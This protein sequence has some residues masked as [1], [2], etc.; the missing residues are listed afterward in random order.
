MPIDQT[1]FVQK[2]TKLRNLTKIALQ[3]SLQ[4]FVNFSQGVSILNELGE[5]MSEDFLDLKHKND[6]KSRDVCLQIVGQLSQSFQFFRESVF[7]PEIAENE[8]RASDSSTFSHSPGKNR[9]S[10]F[11]NRKTNLEG[12]QSYEKFLQK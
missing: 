4:N 10:S 8:T 5:T 3:N 9:E 11:K 7:G 2:H 6:E 1:E 12:E